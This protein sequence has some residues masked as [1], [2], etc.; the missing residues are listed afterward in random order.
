[1]SPRMDEQTRDQ[2]RS[3][4]KRISGQI[5]GISRMLSDDRHSGE[6]LVQLASARAALAT[7]A[8]LILSKHVEASLSEVLRQDEAARQEKIDELLDVF[9]RFGGG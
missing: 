8:K 3:R 7:T 1:M 5:D 6:I 2:A 9:A 4:L